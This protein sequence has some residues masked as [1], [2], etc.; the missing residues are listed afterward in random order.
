MDWQLEDS[1]VEV[2]TADNRRVTARPRR[3]ADGA[4]TL[5]ILPRLRYRLPGARPPSLSFASGLLCA[6]DPED[7]DV[8]VLVNLSDR[9]AV[10]RTP[11][12]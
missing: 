5:E 4:L 7:A 1:E 11:R 9:I 2:M 3:D 8:T 6:A 12:D 10:L